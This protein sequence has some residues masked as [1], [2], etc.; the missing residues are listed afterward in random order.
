V[1]QTSNTQQLANETDDGSTGIVIEEV[2][3]QR[4]QQRYPACSDIREK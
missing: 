4:P 2:P 3:T 1:P